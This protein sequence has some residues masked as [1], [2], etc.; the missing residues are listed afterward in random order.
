VPYTRRLV[1]ERFV[2]L[3]L[4]ATPYSAAYYDSEGLAASLRSAKIV[5][6][7]VMSLVRPSSVIDVG[8]GPGTWLSVFHE[9]GVKRI[10]GLDGDHIDPSW[11]VIPED[12]FHA[13]DLS[14]PFDAG[15]QFDLAIC[16]EVA[17][18]LPKKSS[19]DL[20]RGL[21]ALAPFVLFS[22]AVPLQGG[23]H[24]INE[25]WPEFWKALFQKSGY[26]AL[27][28]IRKEIWK[29]TDVAYWYRQNTF[30]FV[31]EDMISS[32][33]AFLAAADDGDDLMLVRPAILHHQ[34]GVRSLLK[35]LPRSIWE[36][37][38]RR[39]RKIFG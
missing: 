34:M 36:A 12:C 9:C 4:K 33:A 22:A 18:H 7:I 37:A 27:D 19:A 38:S 5:V 20:V 16:L 29:N 13:V 28:P 10:I 14:K 23:V 17:E 30:L 11:L 24:H 8:C 15:G 1:S 2:E 31:R 35:Q 32:N 21:V 25:Q 6:P 3:E 26:R 39:L